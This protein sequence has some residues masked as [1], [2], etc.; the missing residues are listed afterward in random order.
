MRKGARTERELVQMLKEIGIGAIRIA[1]SGKMD[2]A[3]DIIAGKPGRLFIIECKSSKKPHIYV[4]AAEVRNVI[5]Y[6][7]KFGGEP[8][9]A[10]RFNYKPWKFVPAAE[11]LKHTKASP[12]SGITFEAF[13]GKDT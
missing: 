10:F 7:H 2:N 5:S 3:P 1:G 4:S 6:A 9:Y 11:L 13:L 8:W 12:D